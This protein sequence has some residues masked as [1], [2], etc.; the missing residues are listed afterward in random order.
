MVT[1]DG[2]QE[3]QVDWLTFIKDYLNSIDD[4]PGVQPI[5]AKL[6]QLESRQVAKDRELQARMN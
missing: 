2:G 4:G 3:A 6:A 5:D 1:S